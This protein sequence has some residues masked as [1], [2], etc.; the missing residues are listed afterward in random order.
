MNPWSE[1]APTRLHKVNLYRMAQDIFQTLV[2]FAGA[3]PTME[4]DFVRWFTKDNAY[5]SREYRFQGSLGFGGK[6]WRNNKRFYVN[7]YREDE[8]D[9]IREQIEL[10]NSILKNW[11]YPWEM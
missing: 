11:P 6:F 1:P 8:T 4:D 10:V 2:K 7:C 3:N 5:W 9:D